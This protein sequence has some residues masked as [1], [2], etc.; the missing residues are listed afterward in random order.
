MNIIGIYAGDRNAAACLVRG[1][2]LIAFAEEERFNGLKGSPG[3]FPVEAVEFC[4]KYGNI[5]T[6]EIDKIA[7][8]WDC[9]KYKWYMPVFFLKTWLKNVCRLKASLGAEATGLINLL[10]YNPKQL[11][12]EIQTSLKGKY[13]EKFPEIIFIPHHYAHAASSFFCSGFDKAPILTIDGSGEEICTMSAVGEGKQINC[14]D[15]QLIPNSLGWFYA[16]FTEFLGFNPYEDEYKV[17]G[18]SSYGAQDDE[19]TKKLCKVISFNNGVYK[20]DPKYFYFGKH[21]HGK[22]FTDNLVDLF[23]APRIKNYPIEDREKNIAYAIQSALEKAAVN[24]AGK[25]SKSQQIDKLCLAGGVTLNCKMVSA[26]LSSGYVNEVFVQPVGYDSGSALGA[27][28]LVSKQLGFDP[29]FKMEHVYYGPEYSDKEILA[30]LRESKVNY[31][32]C[33]NIEVVVAKELK[34]GKIIGWF[35]GRMEA[36][37]RALGN[38]SILANPALPNIRDKINAEIKHRELWRP[39]AISILDEAKDDFLVNARPSPFMTATFKIKEEKKQQVQAAIHIDGTT[40]PQTVTKE[41]NFKYW[42]LI[43]EFERQTGIPAVLNTSLNGMRKPIS[44]SP[45][46]ALSLFFSSALDVLA[47]GDFLVKKEAK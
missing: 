12:Y 47:I 30:V 8:G 20:I 44:C 34:L 16:G 7:F 21:S 24:L 46:D 14:I 32:H 17:M 45:R 5:T 38:R 29:R 1:G 11:K 4:L 18:L 3:I 31:E 33:D 9:N 43:K 22:R 42:R 2:K 6:G 27:A 39:F 28:L 19:V 15:K 35:Q 13:K 36:G 10:E 26:I 37:P 41:M 40:R 23:G 25:L